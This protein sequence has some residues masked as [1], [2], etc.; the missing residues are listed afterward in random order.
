VARAVQ[1][2]ALRD[3]QT[4]KKGPSRSPFSCLK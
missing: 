3:P 2:F 1:R 4:R